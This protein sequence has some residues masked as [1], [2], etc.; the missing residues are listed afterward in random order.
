MSFGFGVSDIVALSEFV[1]DV[2]QN[3]RSALGAHHELTREVTSLHIILQT[4][5]QE[6]SKPES[7]LNRRENKDADR[8]EQLAVLAS[9]CRRVTRSLSHILKKYDA[10][11]DAKGSAKRLKQRV[12]F[13]NT[14]MKNLGEIRNRIGAIISRITFFINIITLG[15]LGRVEQLM[16]SRRSENPEMKE[17]VFKMDLLLAGQ[18]DKSREESVSSY[19]D[20][21]KMFWRD[22]RKQFVEAGYPSSKLK[23]NKTFMKD[24]IKAVGDSGVLDDRGLDALP[25]LSDN[26]M[27]E[28][29]T[30]IP[31]QHLPTLDEI[32]LC[33]VDDV[34]S[35]DAQ[36]VEYLRG[37]APKLDDG[38]AMAHYTS[39]GR[40]DDSGHSSFHPHSAHYSEE[41]YL[42]DFGNQRARPSMANHREHIQ[43][44]PGNAFSYMRPSPEYVYRHSVPGLTQTGSGNAF[45]FMQPSP[46]PLYNGVLPG[47]STGFTPVPYN[48]VAGVNYPGFQNTT[49]G[50]E[51][52]QF[53][54]PGPSSSNTQPWNPTF[55]P[56]LARVQISKDIPWQRDLI[57]KM[58]E[59]ILW[60][61][62]SALLRENGVPECQNG[63]QR[64]GG[65]PTLALDFCREA[66]AHHGG[67]RAGTILLEPVRTKTKK[68]KGMFSSSSTTTT[69]RTWTP[70]FKPSKF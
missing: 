62:L 55:L 27:S 20:D 48:D 38:D 49:F 11:P 28:H 45:S 17:L 44:D 21:D 46:F 7:L 39:N 34:A 18:Q 50:T 26:V 65:F 14:E 10:V 58:K 51:P 3:T 31:D 25:T 53:F 24:Y 1:C 16:N 22:F 68:K 56:P 64:N 66:Q 9:D 42:Q 43:T 69:M 40:M 32:N 6:V 59:P 60:E 54:E 13:G 52:T 4:L 29:Q 23:K 61:E 12:Q 57:K 5:E 35:N 70:N 41:T 8:R 67:T 47:G 37:L 33:K 15:S 36:G 63:D 19:A 30:T 2:I